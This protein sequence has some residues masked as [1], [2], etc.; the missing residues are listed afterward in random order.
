MAARGLPEHK[1]HA[2]FNGA[3]PASPAGRHRVQGKFKGNGKCNRAGGTP[4]LQRQ[5]QCR[6]HPGAA[7]GDRFNDAGERAL[8]R[9]VREASL[10]G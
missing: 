5:S 6:R 4:A 10:A 8:L 9:L 2:K 3:G 1:G 7:G